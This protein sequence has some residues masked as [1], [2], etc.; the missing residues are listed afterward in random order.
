MEWFGTDTGELASHQERP[1]QENLPPSLH[2]HH[3]RRTMVVTPETTDGQ[4]P[5]RTT[6]DS[7][8]QHTGTPRNTQSS[9]E[10]IEETKHDSNNH[11]HR[12]PEQQN[13]KTPPHQLDNNC[14][15]STSEEQSPK[16]TPN[17]TSPTPS[18]RRKTLSLPPTRRH[19]S[20]PS[21]NKSH[22][23]HRRQEKTNTPTGSP[24]QIIQPS[25]SNYTILSDTEDEPDTTPPSKRKIRKHLTFEESKSPKSTNVD[26]NNSRDS[27]NINTIPETINIKTTTT[28]PTLTR[29]PNNGGSNT[30]GRKKAEKEW[31][32][33]IVHYP[34][35]VLDYLSKT[36][37]KKKASRAR[38]DYGYAIHGNT[39]PTG[40]IHI[41]F[42]SWPGNCKRTRE[43][44]VDDLPT[45]DTRNA[46]AN[47]T[48][49]KIRN[50]EHFLCYLARKG[51]RTVYTVGNGFRKLIDALQTF[52]KDMDV[53]D[54]TTSCIQYINEKRKT[55]TIPLTIDE[56]DG[57]E[58]SGTTVYTKMYDT[59]L[60][61]IQQYKP[62]NF[63]E[64]SRAMDKNTQIYLLKAYGPRY[65]S[66][67]RE[68]VHMH[69]TH[70]NQQLRQTTYWDLVNSYVEKHPEEITPAITN[71]IDNL[72]E[73]NSINKIEFLAKLI[74]IADK[75]LTK[76]NSFILRGEVNTGKSLLLTLLTECMNPSIL[77]RQGDAS[78]FYLQNL[79]NSPAVIFE[80]PTINTININTMKLLMGGEK[81]ATDVK[82][83]NTHIIQ[84]LPCFF[85][86]NTML[87]IDCDQIHREALQIRSYEFI[88]NQQIR[89]STTRGNIPPAPVHLTPTHLYKYILQLKNEIDDKANKIVEEAQQ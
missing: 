49:T 68:M 34:T 16:S 17:I 59:I 71:W 21:P 47:T 3:R 82:N 24:N 45:H 89:S 77:M 31:Y 72:F 83:A 88:L 33:F 81:V 57:P 85:T 23:G 61:Y 48:V 86:T 27:D 53:T 7:N 20:P 26:L 54:S 14:H 58:D 66:F 11:V 1:Q 42:E 70:N 52:K 50:R 84:R 55:R 6:T 51:L 65:T 18:P 87:G 40:H 2:N 8:Q 64:L 19:Y 22:D 56:T 39:Q 73:T 35:D 30:S 46:D 4:I 69:N 74:L 44:I 15:G 25:T 5:S 78:Q 37:S 41:L 80:D 62:S 63:T 10:N 67:A 38:P 60:P 43:R 79:V 13:N 29:R 36:F 76:V 75:K 9:T 32:S 12:Q 28:N